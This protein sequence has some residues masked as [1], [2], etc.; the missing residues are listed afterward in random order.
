MFTHLPRAS[1]TDQPPLP[2][3]PLHGS[4]LAAIFFPFVEKSSQQ[5]SNLQPSA[6]EAGALSVEL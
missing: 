2:L 4:H 3:Q 6:S 5:D 1:C